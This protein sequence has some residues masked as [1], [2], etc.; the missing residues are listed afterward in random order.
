MIKQCPRC[1]EV[2][3]KDDAMFCH[4][5]GAPLKDLDN[6]GHCGEMLYPHFKFCRKC[7]FKVGESWQKS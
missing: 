4:E 2:S 5:D 1:K 3:V 6:C 7:G